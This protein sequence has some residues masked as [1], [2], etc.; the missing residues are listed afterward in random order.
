MSGRPLLVL[1]LDETLWYGDDSAAKVKF[2]L[3]PHLEAFLAAVAEHYDLAV[4]TNASQDWMLAGL[5]EVKFHTG[6]DLSQRAVFLWDR[7][8]STMRRT[9]AGAYE[10]RKPARKFRAGWLRSRYPRERILVLDD[11][12]TNYACGFGHLVRVSSWTG[13]VDDQELLQLAAYIVSI[14]GTPNFRVLEKRG[15]RSA[16]QLNV[17]STSG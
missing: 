7:R 9:D 8:R 1:D 2:L 14:A 11:Q 4:W 16:R 6:F 17:L 5:E 15:W 10:W 12:P 13:A 3:R